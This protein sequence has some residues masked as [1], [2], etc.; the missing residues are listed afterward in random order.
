MIHVECPDCSKS[1]DV[2]EELAGKAAKC[3]A[4]GGR[5]PIPQR[6]TESDTTAERT[7]PAQPKPA[8]TKSPLPKASTAVP[9]K[10]KPTTKPKPAPKKREEDFFDDD[11][12]EV[13]EFDD[14][15]VVEDFDD[16][17]D[18]EQIPR[19]GTKLQPSLRKKNAR[20]NRKSGPSLASKALSFFVGSFVWWAFLAGILTCAGFAWSFHADPFESRP[21]AQAVAWVGL[22][23]LFASAIWMI[24]VTFQVSPGWGRT[25][26]IGWLVNFGLNMGGNRAIVG[27]ISLLFGAVSLILIVQH[28]KEFRA[29]F[30]FQIVIG[31]FLVTPLAAVIGVD[32]MRQDFEARI[33]TAGPAAGESAKPDAPFNVASIPIPGFKEMRLRVIQGHENALITTDYSGLQAQTPGVLTIMNYWQPVGSHADRSLACVLVASAGSTLLHGTTAPNV[34]YLAE[35]LPYVDAG[36]AV[37]GVS[38]DGPILNKDRATDRDYSLA[39]EQF[40]RSGAG[41]VNVRNAVEFLINKVPQVDPKRIYIAGHSS[42]ATLALLAAQHEPRLKGCIAYAPATDVVSRLKSVIDNSAAS[43]VFPDV[44]DFAKQSSPLTHVSKIGC[45]VFLFHAADDSNTPVSDSRRF[46]E[47]LK[48][49]G[50]AVTYVEVPTGNHYDSMIQQGIPTAIPWLKQLAGVSDAARAPTAQVTPTNP[51]SS[52][53]PKGAE[54]PTIPNIAPSKSGTPAGGIL[55]PSGRAVTFR[56]RSFSGKGDPAAAV[57]QALRNVTWAD[58]D[59]IVIV[60]VIGEI[61]IGQLGGTIDVNPAR[62]ALLDAGFQMLPGVSIGAKPSTPSTTPEPTRPANTQ[63]AAPITSTPIENSFTTKTPPSKVASKP[64]TPAVTE[65]AA[66][67]ESGPPRRVVTFRYERYSGK[68]SSTNA[69]VAALKRVK[70]ADPDDIEVDAGKHEI[71]VGQLEESKEYGPAEKALKNAGFGL[72]PGVT[73]GLRKR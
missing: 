14:V 40:R 65:P 68:G 48:S 19:F 37:L 20:R 67:K 13:A 55:Q 6:R 46:A 25:F 62:Q 2:A 41:T 39:Y 58:L 60:Q 49:N 73:S 15:E 45:P 44:A 43:R 35:T 61:R 71:R 8:P 36:F 5:I 47:L 52:A 33:P 24:V 34:S 21:L 22:P 70:W 54:L 16:V 53:A 56:F 66:P 69:A 1:Y 38:L 31:M 63:P 26:L 27:G 3:R 23:L 11:F 18:D 72:T 57:R 50:K 7:K 4:C 42:A 64:A 17:E 32:R 28:W 59:D 30:L 10:S 29:V 9:A 51:A 12:E